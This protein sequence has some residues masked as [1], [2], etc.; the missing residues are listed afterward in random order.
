M[1][2]P[3]ILIIAG[4]LVEQHVD[5]IV[6]AANNDLLLGGGVAG[7]IR[8]RGGPAIQRECDAHGPIKVGQAAITGGG[9]LP[10]HSVIHA[11]SMQLGGRTTIDA[12]RSSMDDAFRLAHEHGVRT[13]AVPAVGTGIAGF[14]MDECAR[15]MRECVER[16]L[17]AGWQPDEIRFVLFGDA[18]RNDFE[19]SFNAV[20]R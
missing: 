8:E 5:A 7:A 19:E 1:S 9:E 17:T 2:A 12:L 11:A 18:A 6:N 3:R 15:V 13:I 20:E 10:A 4:D 16:A 14:P